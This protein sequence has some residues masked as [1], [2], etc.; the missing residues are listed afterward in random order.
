MTQ[1]NPTIT[2]WQGVGL[3][4]TAL[5]GTSVFILPQLT[6]KLAADGAVFAWALLLL[7]MLPV[8]LVFAKLGQLYPDA[9][10]P[11]WYVRQA[12]GERAGA[13]I[14][15]LFLAVAPIGLPAA[16][17]MTMAFADLLVPLGEEAK[18]LFELGLMAMML[19]LNYRGLQLSGQLQ[20]GLTI[21]ILAVFAA[22]ILGNVEQIRAPQ[23]DQ[24]SAAPVLTAAGVALWA[25][26]GVEAFSHLSA[27]FKDPQRDFMPAMMWGTILVGLVYMAGTALVL[28]AEQE[29]VAIAT[30]FDQLFGGGGAVVI[31]GLGVLA[32]IATMNTYFNSMARLTWSLAKQGYLPQQFVQLNSAQVPARALVMLAL[33]QGASLLLSYWLQWDFE[34]LLA[35]SNG[36]F[37]LVYLLSM[38]AGWRLLGRRYKVVTAMAS[39]LIL[40]L[41]YSVGTHMF[42]A[43]GALLIAMLL[44]WLKPKSENACA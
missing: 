24:L 44:L 35:P 25:F 3:L 12:F 33:L 37:V 22:M 5:L 30:L 13:A 34:H 27:E 26:L 11:S 14:G 31:G 16:M 38:L 10:G 2:R 20:F 19:A 21:V 18:L 42:Y 15:L 17:M 6:V 4:S 29:G 32:G 8:A 40:L 39:V 23:L 1:L 41:G 36:I 7:A 28:D 9:G 43:I